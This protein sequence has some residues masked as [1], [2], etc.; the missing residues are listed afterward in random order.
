MDWFDKETGLLKLDEYVVQHS[1]FKKVMADGIVTDEE[2]QECAET[3]A[4]KLRELDVKL[5]EDLKPLATD[6][7]CELSVLYAVMR[8]Y[9][10]QEASHGRF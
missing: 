9:E 2:L 3:A 10:M 7:L 8:H 6:A 1:S 5:P 4:T